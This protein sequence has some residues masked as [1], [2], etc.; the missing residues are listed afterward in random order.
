[1]K[2]TESNKSPSNPRIGVPD[3]RAR[4]GKFDEVELAAIKSRGDL[5][6]QIQA[7]YGLNKLQA[8]TNVDVWANGRQF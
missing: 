1:M 3:L 7:K 8:E 5:V 2:L 4:W 6:M